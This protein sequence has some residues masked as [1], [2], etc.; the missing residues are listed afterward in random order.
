MW[1]KILRLP[2]WALLLIV[3]AGVIVIALVFSSLNPLNPLNFISRPPTKVDTSQ[4]AVVRQIQSLN[5]LETA[6]YAVDKV[7]TAGT[8]GNAFQNLLY[9]DRI[10]LVA[11][12]TVVA[13]VDLSKVTNNDVKVSGS[14]LNVHL[15]N[16]EIFSTD[17]DQNQTKV[18]DRQQGLLS[19]GDKDLES[20]A[21]A[22]AVGQI[23]QAACSDGILQRAADEAK[24]RISQ[25]Y[26]L[27]GFATINVSVI[28][29]KC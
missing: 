11:H 29:G 26:K 2:V 12:G 5:R 3:L 21:R 6:S 10:L 15:P 25:M 19:K 27:V 7:I 22:A 13:G 4:T 28:P 18:F 23:A 16:T 9:G 8:D 20:Q 17:L 1:L 14:T 24:D